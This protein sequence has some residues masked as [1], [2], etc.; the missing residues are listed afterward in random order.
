MAVRVTVEQVSALFP[1]ADPD[2]TFEQITDAITTANTIVEERLVTA[3]TPALTT[4]SVTT[5]LQIEK[6][7]AAHFV[8]L[9][10][11]PLAREGV[12][13]ISESAQQKVDLGLLY[14]KYGQQAVLLDS[15]GVLQAMTAVKA[16]PQSAPRQ[17]SAAGAWLLST[18]RV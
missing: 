1:D 5:L 17:G 13:I 15:T 3:I 9:I 12:S 16:K 2:A 14:T 18:G 11:T 10:D 6:Y 4:L 7:L 8:A